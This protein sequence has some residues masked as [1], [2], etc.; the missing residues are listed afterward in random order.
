[1][2][3]V[4]YNFELGGLPASAPIVSSSASGNSANRPV[5]LHRIGEVRQEQGVS[6]RSAARRMGVSMQ[7]VRLQ[8][9]AD[10]DLRLSQLLEWQRVLDVPLADLLTDCNSPLSTPVSE[11]ARM[12]RVMKTVKALAESTS[13]PPVQRLA[14][15]L[16]SQLVDLMPELK[17][18]SAWHSVGQR[19]TQEEMGR[20][21]ERTIPDS[22]FGDGNY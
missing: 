2:S 4:E 15:M 8:E 17:E 16:I 7:E 1:M 9:Q 19:R 6:V 5:V 11:R 22:F 3:T 10:Q 12:L 13:E 14:S 20:I 18:V 21:V